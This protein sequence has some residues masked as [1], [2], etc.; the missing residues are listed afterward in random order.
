MTDGTEVMSE[1]RVVNINSE[2]TNCQLVA[3]PN[4]R[5]QG[6]LKYEPCMA[7]GALAGEICPVGVASAQQEL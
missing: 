3:L 4:S 2:L 1:H 5:Y 6:L 7:V